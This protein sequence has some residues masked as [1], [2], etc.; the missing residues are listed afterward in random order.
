MGNWTSE[1]EFRGEVC[2]EEMHLEVVGIWVEFKEW[3]LMISS[4]EWVYIEKRR[5]CP[6]PGAAL[7]LRYIS[8][9]LYSSIYCKTDTFVKENKSK[10]LEKGNGIKIK[11]YKIQAH[12]FIIRVS[13]CKI[14]F[15]Q[16]NQK[17]NTIKK[18]WPKLHIVHW[19]YGY[20]WLI[21]A[22]HLYLF[23]LLQF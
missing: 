12:I 20:R 16:Y 13:K 2:A 8:H 6:S 17:K 10:L 19:N 22:L 23:I 9:L 18:R 7:I 14:T 11:T 1:A 3:V 5:I 21:R 15:Q 4:W